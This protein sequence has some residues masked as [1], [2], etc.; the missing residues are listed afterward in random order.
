LD[1]DRAGVFEGCENLKEIIVPVGH[2]QR[3]ADLFEEKD[4]MYKQLLIEK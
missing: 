1:S 2:K 4:A 3:I